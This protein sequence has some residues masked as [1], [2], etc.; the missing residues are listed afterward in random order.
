MA[1]PGINRR[2][3]LTLQS[4]LVITCTLNSLRILPTG[5]NMH[6]VSLRTENN[7]FPVQMK[8]TAFSFNKMYVCVYREI[9]VQC[10]FVNTKRMNPRL[11]RV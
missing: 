2:V 6:S 7:K 4:T 5:C 1:V 8:P 3:V 11:Q 9:L 10:D